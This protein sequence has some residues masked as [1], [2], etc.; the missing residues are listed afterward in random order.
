MKTLVIHPLD[1]T[2][3]MLSLIYKDKNFN[4]ITNPNISSDELKLAIK[5]HERIIMLGHGLPGGLINPNVK[6]E[7]PKLD[8]LYLI[9]DS[10][11]DLL[12]EKETISIWCF[13]DI[14]FKR[15]QMTGFHT[16]MIISEVNEAKH[17]LGHAPLNEQQLENNMIYLCKIIGQ[18]IE[19]APAKMQDYILTHYQGD[20]EITQFNRKNILVL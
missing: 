20:D 4:V 1:E 17:I 7:L 9:D 15:H 12:M 11:A 8:N 2:T 14:Y 6:K 18:C 19:M 10:Y 3:N 5:E 13:S 16:G